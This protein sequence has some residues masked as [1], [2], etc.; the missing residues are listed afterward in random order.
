METLR[1][2]A[3]CVLVMATS[4]SFA[5]KPKK[6]PFQVIDSK[7]SYTSKGTSIKRFDFLRRET[8]TVNGYL[9]IVHHYGYPFTFEGDT[10]VNLK[11]LDEELTS[12]SYPIAMSRPPI[13]KLFGTDPFGAAVY[14]IHDYNPLFVYPPP[15]T[16][17]VH[18]EAEDLCL[19]WQAG[20]KSYRLDI[21]S[22]YDDSLRTYF[23]DTNQFTLPSTL[24]PEL[25]TDLNMLILSIT[26][27][28]KRQSDI[29]CRLLKDTNIEGLFRCDVKSASE[30]LLIGYYNEN[31]SLLNEAQ[32]YYELA[33]Q[34]SDHEVFKEALNHFKNRKDRNHQLL[35]KLK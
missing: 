23:V 10:I 35:K 18:N 19:R 4:S 14:A 22:L 27:D 33:T 1:L 6:F 15:Q 28:N 11:S 30:A 13:E 17:L 24:F 26:L 31:V 32:Q 16:N 21:K 2:W 9:H 29:S 34:A 20:S 5:Q 7:N 25:K 8:V 12:V 3:F